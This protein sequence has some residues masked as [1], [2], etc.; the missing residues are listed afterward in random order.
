M[1]DQANPEAVLRA[2]GQYQNNI[3][4]VVST[5]PGFVAGGY[6][7]N[8][9]PIALVGRVPVRVST[10]N[11]PIQAGDTLTS[12]SIPGYAMK[13]TMAGRALG[14]A[15]EAFDP[16]M[17]VPCPSQ[18]LGN[19]VATKCGSVMMFVNLANYYGASI[20]MAMTDEQVTGVD[21]SGLTS[22]EVS[23]ETDGLLT[24]ASVRLAVSAPTKETEMLEYLK[25][26]HNTRL[27]SGAP[28]SEVLADRISATGEI[29]SP[30]IIA[31]T[32]FA[33]HIKADSIEGLQ[34]FTDQLSSLSEK[35]AGLTTPATTDPTTPAV[36]EQLAV[37][38]KKLSVDSLAVQFDGSIL[39]KLSVAGALRIGGDA[40]FD[41]NTVFSKLATFL[42][43]TLFSGHVA[44]EQ[45]PMFG[46][47]TAGFALIKKGEQKVH[48]SFATPY[49]KQPIVA[50]SMT[51]DKSPLLD[52]GADAAL[53]GDVAAV[54]EDYLNTMFGADIKYIVTEKS[55][56]GFTIVLNKKVPYD[57]QF[58]WVAIAVKKAN[59]AVSVEENKSEGQDIVSLPPVPLPKPIPVSVTPPTPPEVTPPA[60]PL[61][62][63]TPAH[64]VSPVSEIPPEVTSTP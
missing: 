63:E 5:K 8:S 48:V 29:I 25:R 47:D 34:V 18:G 13:A 49:D 30:T 38:M 11:G 2:T 3:I 16:A 6:T 37:A 26:L 55:V 64:P 17:A 14:R 7:D 31:D 60:E 46:S 32:I 20:E 59:T 19:D 53:Q 44:F 50:V 24:P 9:Y 1:I 58:S 54:E 33:K 22:S 56:E 39:G 12:A 45:T 35:Y 51:N 42:G 21:E 57:L 62:P 61:I 43:D 40:Q 52:G 41:G 36:Q 4:G 28:S 23:V 10:E 15:L 27:A